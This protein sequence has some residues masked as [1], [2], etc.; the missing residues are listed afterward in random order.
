MRF[1]LLLLVYV[2]AFACTAAPSQDEQSFVAAL[3]LGSTP[4]VRYLDSNGKPLDYAAFAQQLSERRSYSIS[5]DEQAGM[6]M[7][8]IRPPGAHAGEPGRFSF[9][10][11]DA[12]PP[13]ALPS[14]QGGMRRL[15]DFRGR[16]TLV[17]FFFAEC[18]PCIAEVPTLNA[19]ARSHGDVNVVAITFEDAAQA[20]GFVEDRGLT[21][22]VLYRGVSLTDTLGVGTY[23]TLM[24]LDPDGRVAGA[25]VGM[26]LSDDPAQRL[27]DLQSWIAQWKQ[28]S[29]HPAL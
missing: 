14:L 7:L 17:S 24:L 15:S 23:P 18:A 28:A 1:I 16:Y 22:N 27:A 3:Q 8:R 5:R 4:H 9:G 29:A 26:S 12:F 13:F 10:R 20:R 2:L 6:A 11:G 25:A 19:Y 21:W